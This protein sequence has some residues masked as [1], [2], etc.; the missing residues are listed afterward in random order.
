MGA[1]IAMQASA[2]HATM[3]KD[4]FIA[5]SLFRCMQMSRFFVNPWISGV[6]FSLSAPAAKMASF[7]GTDCFAAPERRNHLTRSRGHP[8]C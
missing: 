4:R 6:G 3:S 8:A 2:K 7:N 5:V 1:K